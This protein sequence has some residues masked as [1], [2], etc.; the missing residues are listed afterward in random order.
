MRTLFD[1]PTFVEYDYAVHFLY[2]TEPVSN[3]ERS[4]SLHKLTEGCLNSKLAFGIEG[5]GGL[6]EY[7]DGGVFENGSGNGDSLALSAR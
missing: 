7:Q 1:N 6:I 5:R 4:S 2:C 3:N